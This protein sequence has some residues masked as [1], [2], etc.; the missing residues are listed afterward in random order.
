VSV[1][2][3][4]LLEEVGV[5]NEARDAVALWERLEV[6]Q[7]LKRLLVHGRLSDMLK[8]ERYAQVAAESDRLDVEG[9]AEFD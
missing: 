3:E 8:R 7:R 5:I 9:R 6:E 1:L 2:E 4:L